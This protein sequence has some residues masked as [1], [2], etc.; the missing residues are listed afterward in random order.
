[1]DFMKTYGILFGLCLF[2]SLVQGV[3]G[4]EKGKPMKEIRTYMPFTYPLDPVRI[5][6]IADLDISYALASTLVEWNRQKQVTSALAESWAVSERNFRFTLRKDGR[7]SDGTFISSEE[8]KQS[9]VRAMK[10][11]PEDVRSLTNILDT[12]ECPNSHE[13]LFRLKVPAAES[14]LLKKLTEPIG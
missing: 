9:F 3:L 14:D 7:W 4:S 8:V 12:I 10:S 5:E 13:I 11:Y 1:M 2:F 6:T